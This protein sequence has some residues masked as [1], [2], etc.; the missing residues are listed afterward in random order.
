MA[1]VGR[2]HLHEPAAVQ[3]V[4]GSLEGAFQ[5]AKERCMLRQKLEID[6]AHHIPAEPVVNRRVGQEPPLGW[7]QGRAQAGCLHGAPVAAW[8]GALDSH[9]GYV[10]HV[11][12]NLYQSR[13]R[14]NGGANGVT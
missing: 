14:T 10:D 2:R 5:A 9:R 11:S 3:V 4:V 12:R 8:H 13:A 1:S 7:W 6:I